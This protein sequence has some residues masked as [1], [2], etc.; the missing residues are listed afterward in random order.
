MTHKFMWVIFIVLAVWL[1]KLMLLPDEPAGGDGE[2]A[3]RGVFA[4]PAV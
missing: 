4:W 3:G 2:E 1:V